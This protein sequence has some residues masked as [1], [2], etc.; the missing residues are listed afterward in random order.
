LSREDI[1]LT[2]RFGNNHVHTI[3]LQRSYFIHS[4]DHTIAQSYAR[5][6]KTAVYIISIK[7]RLLAINNSH[8]CYSEH[9]LYTTQQA[10]PEF[11]QVFT[12]PLSYVPQADTSTHIL[13]SDLANK[14][15]HHPHHSHQK[16]PLNFFCLPLI[17]DRDD[18]KDG[19]S[20]TISRAATRTVEDG[21]HGSEAGLP[22]EAYACNE[23]LRDIPAFLRHAE[24]TSQELFFDLCKSMTIHYV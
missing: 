16:K 21:R 4:H 13:I 9:L 24:A 5:Y 10:S 20:P 23:E 1:D 7:V 8:H 18:E 15:S 6:S 3:P 11:S 14:M 2:S 22:F 19:V 12:N 17:D